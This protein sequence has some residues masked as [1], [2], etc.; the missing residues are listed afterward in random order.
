[1]SA[2]ARSDCHDI[3]GLKNL[4]GHSL[5]FDASRATDSFLCQPRWGEKLRREIFDY[6]VLAFDAAATAALMAELTG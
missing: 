6:Q 5:V 4:C 3:L 1:M 2:Y